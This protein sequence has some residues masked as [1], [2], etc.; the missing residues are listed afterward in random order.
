MCET[1]MR[2]VLGS[3]IFKVNFAICESL[4]GCWLFKKATKSLK[5][6]KKE[7]NCPVCLSQKLVWVQIYN[8]A[9]KVR[10]LVFG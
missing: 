7:K 6:K 10:K 8:L 5:N 4:I 2:R 9:Q 3:Q 1:K